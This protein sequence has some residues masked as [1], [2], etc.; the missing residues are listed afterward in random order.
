MKKRLF[1]LLAAVLIVTTVF[2]TVGFADFGDFAGGSDW[3]GS[4]WGDSSWDS[5]WGSSSDWDYDYYSGSGSSGDG[6][7]IWT[8]IVFVAIVV[9]AIVGNRGKGRNTRGGSNRGPVNL[10][11]QPTAPLVN[12]LDELK[13][14]DPN[15][16]EAKFL[17]DASNLYVRMQN[18]WTD[19]NLEPIRP[20]L[21]AELYAK[22]EA[23]IDGYK[24]RNETDHVERVSV[25]SANIVGCNADNVNDIVTVQIVAR[26]TDY[27]TD[28]NTG[29]II[30]GSKNKELFMTYQ[31][32]FIRSLGKT[33]GA[34]G[35]ID[36]E[37]CP[38]CGAPL[39]LNRSAVCSY[40]GATITS[41]DYDWV[42]SNIKGISQRSV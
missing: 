10:G 4:D 41:G 38:N 17:D 14:K 8:A 40:C 11:Q 19:K 16:S 31:W 15:F 3:G 5:D 9:L 32:T 23:Q 26:I 36:S 18:C 7:F 22:S 13:K 42:V 20:H 6:D 27:V 1:C 2:A 24:R 33:T 37:H 21:S 35:G 25:L 28:D 30:R 12:R 39:D 34:D 29:A